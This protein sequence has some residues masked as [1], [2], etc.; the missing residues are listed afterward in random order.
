MGYWFFPKQFNFSTK[1]FVLGD[2]LAFF[3][4][5]GIATSVLKFIDGSLKMLTPAE[6][7]ARHF[8]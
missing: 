7:D 1:H 5:G 4:D 2:L 8:T 3:H 6:F